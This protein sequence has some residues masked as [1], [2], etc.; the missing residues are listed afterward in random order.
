MISLAEI[1]RYLSFVCQFGNGCDF[2]LSSHLLLRLLNR[3]V[4]L[5][6]ERHLNVRQA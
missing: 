6:G 4:F 1:L 5:R 3:L 2:Y